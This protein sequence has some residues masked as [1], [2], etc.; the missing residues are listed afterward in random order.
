MTLSGDIKHE[1]FCIAEEILDSAGIPRD[2][3]GPA[4]NKIKD[5]IEKLAA[6]ILEQAKK[7]SGFGP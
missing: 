5:R 3:Q 4:L 6:A 2:K 1:A 7:Q